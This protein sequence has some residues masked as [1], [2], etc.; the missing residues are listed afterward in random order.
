DAKLLLSGERDFGRVPLHAAREVR[1][2]LTNLGRSTLEVIDV[3]TEDTDGSYRASFEHAGPHQLLAGTD[4]TVILSFQPRREGAFPGFFVVRSDSKE[5][6]VLR[7]PLNGIGVDAR[8]RI[9]ETRLDFGKIEL[10]SEKVKTL[11]LENPSDLSILVTP[12]RL[13]ADHDEFHAEPITLGPYEKRSLEVTF[14][15]TRVGTKQAALGVAPCEGCVDVSVML[16]AEGLDRAIVAEPPELDFGPVPMDRDVTRVVTLRNI[17]TEPREVTGMAL[18]PTTD[19]SFTHLSG[20]APVILQGGEAR[21]FTFRYSPGHMGGAAGEVIFSVAST[22]NP[23]IKVP[24][25]GFG[26]APELCVSPAEH[27]FGPQPVGAKVWVSVTVRNCGSSNSAPLTVTDVLVRPASSG[28]GGSDQFNLTTIAL[29][30]TLAAGEEFAVR[31]FYEPTALGDHAATISLRT[32]GFAASAAQV[33]VT[34]KAEPHAPCQ[35]AITPASVDFG[36]VVPGRYGILGVK[37]HNI[38]ADVCPVKNIEIAD[39]GG[40]TFSMPG[41]SLPGVVVHASYYFSFMV[42][43]TAPATPGTFSGSLKIEVWDPTNP[44]VYVPLVGNS[45]SS[46]LIAWPTYLDFGFTRPD[47]P[48][49]PRAFKLE[50]VCA[51]PLQVRSMEIGPGTTDGEFLLTKRP[52]PLPMT[53]EPGATTA[54]EV[55]Y[56]GQVSGMN[57]S[58]LYVDVEG[59]LRPLLVPLMGES[60]INGQA[61]DRFVQQDGRKVDV[62]FVVDNTA[63]MVEE[64]PKLVAAIPSFI[65]EAQARG[66]DLHIAVTTTGVDPASATCPG[67]AS[68]A[69]AGRFFPVDHARSRML[70]LQTPDVVSTLQANVQVGQCAFVEQG[71]EAMRR[72]LSSPLV[73]SSDDPR[74]P[75]PADGNAGFLRPEAA[76]AVV[77]VGDE[78]DHSPDEVDAYV[79]WLRALKGSN[80]PQRS[81]LYA[82][83]PTATSC[84]TA[85]GTGTRYMDAATQTGGEVLSACAGDYAPLLQ[86]VARKAFSPQDRFALSAT[87][88]PGSVQLIVDGVEQGSGWYFDP[89]SNQVVFSSLPG[90]GARIEVRYRRACQN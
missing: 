21:E 1:V 13:G 64:H 17:S 51:A 63:S 44:V 67:G 40:G 54:A 58:P 7:V 36:T 56:R 34:G 62:L 4:C 18:A 70:T 27:A 75:Q 60:S 72:A 69:E 16:V 74:T 15:P 5:E 10:G 31:I 23:E 2:T 37:I 49:A 73:D 89:A 8:A 32:N 50:N 6:P 81:T 68:G 30:R 66:V 35:L 24:M 79:R 45:Q 65:S 22:R 77:F 80:Q 48:S 61:V 84:A 46:C 25:G 47:C 42:Q 39:D 57:L 82:I 83:A 28:A 43:F 12:R 3:W 53:L 76:L 88:E 38:G 14:R 29:P 71:F 87:P 52:E 33:Q 11:A 26:G 20:T 59:L 55:E 41:G 78:D 9:A 19:P 86:Q 90:A 85:G